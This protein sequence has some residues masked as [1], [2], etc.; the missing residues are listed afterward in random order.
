[1]YSWH[2]LRFLGRKTV[3][4]DIKNWVIVNILAVKYSYFALMDI[5]FH[6]DLNISVK[7]IM[8]IQYRE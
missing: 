6:Y 3:V 2:A 4:A 7:F 8:F 1:M 5:F